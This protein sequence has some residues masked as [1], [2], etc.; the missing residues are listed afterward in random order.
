MVINYFDIIAGGILIY[1]IIKG[2]VNGFVVELASTVAFILGVLGA[3]MIGGWAE[4]FLGHWV[5]WPYL[6][7]VAFLLVF[8]IVVVLTYLLGN[9]VTEL[10]K[11]SALNVFNRVLGCVFST[12]KFAFLVSVGIAVIGYFDK[13]SSVF[14][15]SE[16]GNSYLY[17]PLSQFAPTIFPFI[18]FNAIKGFFNI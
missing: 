3:V 15:P 11:K 10:L 12:L 18:D 7:I 16:M 17:V 6:G 9:T 13:N 8:M 4:S 2:F 1:A 5:R 14:P